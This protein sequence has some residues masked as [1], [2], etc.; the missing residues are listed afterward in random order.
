[1]SPK[2]LRETFASLSSANRTTNTFYPIDVEALTKIASA[3]SRDP[4]TPP[5]GS[6]A[7]NFDDSGILA[8][9]ILGGV[10]FVALMFGAAWDLM[11]RKKIR[12]ALELHHHP[13]AASS[14]DAEKNLPARTDAHH[15]DGDVP[16]VPP[17][18]RERWAAW[19]HPDGAAKGQVSISCDPIEP[20]PSHTRPREFP[21]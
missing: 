13:S 18:D 21:E 16:P 20:R 3:H 15:D 10:A 6:S 19:G 9:A 2:L 17:L 8:S 11:R 1:V 5:S 7:S 12:E 14:R 4:A